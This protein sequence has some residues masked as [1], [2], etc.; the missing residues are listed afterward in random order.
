MNLEN[1]RNAPTVRSYPRMVS[2]FLLVLIGGGV[3]GLIVRHHELAVASADVEIEAR[4]LAELVQSEVNGITSSMADLAA[5][6]GMGD[7]MVSAQDFTS[8]VAQSKFSELDLV[9]AVG[10]IERVPRDQLQK[11]VDR[12]RSAGRP[13][14]F[15]LAP[16]ATRGGDALLLTRF[17]LLQS[18]VEVPDIGVDLSGFSQSV[19]ELDLTGLGRGALI[20][21]FDLQVAQKT[22]ASFGLTELSEALAARPDVHCPS[23]L[24]SGASRRLGSRIDAAPSLR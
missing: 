10:A 14:F 11:V 15:V 7:H 2:A 4:Q 20:Q 6:V 5:L 22:V 16:P 17:D 19:V 23:A 13:H 24:R 9:E 8:Y 18:D 21:E 12:E 3:I 1:H